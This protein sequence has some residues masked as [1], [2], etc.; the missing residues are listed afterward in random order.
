MK[1]SKTSNNLT[2]QSETKTF[3]VSLDNK[4]R[5]WSVKNNELGI[6]VGKKS[7]KIK[8]SEYIKFIV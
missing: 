2:I 5:K 8:H 6:K 1:K 3:L 7:P 4:K